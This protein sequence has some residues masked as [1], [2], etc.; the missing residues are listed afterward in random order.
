MAG[1]APLDRGIDFEA[2][3]LAKTSAAACFG[4]ETL[5]FWYVVLTFGVLAYFVAKPIG[6][7]TGW[8]DR[9]AV[10]RTPRIDA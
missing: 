7:V 4:H 6:F 8:N 1:D 10:A 5:S 9:A 3:C 2:D